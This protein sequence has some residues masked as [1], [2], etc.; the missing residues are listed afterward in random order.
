MIN[1][2]ENKTIMDESHAYTTV[3]TVRLLVGEWAS[4]FEAPAPNRLD[5]YL[6]RADDLVAAV[7]GLRVKRLGYLSAITGLDLGVETGELEVLYHFCTRALIV[8]LRVRLP[9]DGATVPTLSEIIPV[10]EPFERELQEMLGVT[11]VGLRNNARL[12]LP[13]DWPEGVYPLRKDFDS[14]V[15]TNGER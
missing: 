7:A 3:E 4:A 2:G 9:R 14:Q 10:A 13:D 5:V 1:T 8:T 11:V 15:L 12:Y 6:K